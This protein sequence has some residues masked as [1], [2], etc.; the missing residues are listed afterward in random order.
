MMGTADNKMIVKTKGG[1]RCH[2]KRQPGPT[3]AF[4]MSTTGKQ[5]AQHNYA[6]DEEH[7]GSPTLMS[8]I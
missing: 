3:L 5:R 2:R 6:N 4:E 7:S 8:F 1:G